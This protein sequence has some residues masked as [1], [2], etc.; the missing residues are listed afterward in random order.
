MTLLPAGSQNIGYIDYQKFADLVG[1][2]MP[3]R[4]DKETV[5]KS[6]YKTLLKDMGP[7]FGQLE[8]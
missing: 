2:D 5:R 4:T 3:K 8:N 7:N 1:Y 6:F